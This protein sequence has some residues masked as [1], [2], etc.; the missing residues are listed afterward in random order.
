[1]ISLWQETGYRFGF[2]EARIVERIHLSGALP[3][4]GVRLLRRMEDQ[5]TVLVKRGIVLEGGWAQLESPLRT[6]PGDRFIAQL[7]S[8]AHLDSSA[9]LNSVAHLDSVDE[10]APEPT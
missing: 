9:H 4:Q 8:V 5:E 6:Q 3:G 7:D 2:I 10:S 1:M